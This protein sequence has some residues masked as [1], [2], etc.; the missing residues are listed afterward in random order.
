MHISKDGSYFIKV[1]QKRGSCAN[2]LRNS[3]YIA[4]IGMIKREPYLGGRLYNERSYEPIVNILH[5]STPVYVENTE[6]VKILLHYQIKY[7]V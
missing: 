2:F 6:L 4:D 1:Y 7:K 3:C 5:T